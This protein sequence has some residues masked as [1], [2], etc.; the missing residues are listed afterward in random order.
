MKH[1]RTKYI[2]FITL[3]LTFAINLAYAA[4]KPP[5]L[6]STANAY[7]KS[8]AEWS[9]AWLEWAFS[10][11][12]DVNPLLD[13]TGANA[14]EGQS[15]HIWFLAGTLE[16][17][18][19]VRNIT[20][21]SGNSLFFPIVNSWWVNVPELGDN[22]WSDDQE[23]YARDYNAGVVDTAYDLSLEID[24]RSVNLADYRFE[25]TLVQTT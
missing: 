19:V 14:A 9:A 10:I 21:S 25:S 15:G 20:V 7:G 3:L 12:T 23:A 18:T 5:L 1:Q 13:T 2:V 24:G 17:G 16:T 11:P 8:Y 4:P 6:P 22:P